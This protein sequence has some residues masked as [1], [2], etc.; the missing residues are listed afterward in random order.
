M[1]NYSNVYLY[2]FAK[3]GFTDGCINKAS[4]MGNVSLVT[5]KDILRYESIGV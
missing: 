2:L 3:S 1:F 5:Y 4:E